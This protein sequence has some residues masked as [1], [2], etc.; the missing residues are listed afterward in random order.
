[1]LVGE[2][3]FRRG[4]QILL[5]LA[6][7]RDR[8]LAQYLGNSTSWSQDREPTFRQR[9]SAQDCWLRVINQQIRQL[10][11]WCHVFKGRHQELHGSRTAREKTVQGYLCWHFCSWS[12]SICYEYGDLALWEECFY[13]RPNLQAHSGQELGCFLERL[14]WRRRG[15]EKRQQDCYSRIKRSSGQNAPIQLQWQANNRRN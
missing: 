10:R 1:M 14:G 7:R 11:T 9:L 13:S 2:K 15:S 6:D 3:F 5:P 4:E 8:I 12:C